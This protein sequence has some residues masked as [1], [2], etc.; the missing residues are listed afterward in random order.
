MPGTL[1]TARWGNKPPVGSRLNRAHPLAKGLSLCYLVNEPRLPVH[2]YAGRYNWHLNEHVDTSNPGKFRGNRGLLIEANSEG[3]K[4]DGISGNKPI[5]FEGVFSWSMGLLKLSHA[6]AE[7]VTILDDTP[8]TS[9]LI[10]IRMDTGS[11]D[12]QSF[13]RDT[14]GV[15]NNHTF[16]SAQTNVLNKWMCLTSNATDQSRID[17]FAN[18]VLQSKNATNQGSFTFNRMALGHHTSGVAVNECMIAYFYLYDR[19]FSMHE[20]LALLRN[21]YQ[22]FHIPF[23]PK[24]PDF[25]RAPIDLIVQASIFRFISEIPSLN[26]FKAL[27]PQQTFGANFFNYL[28]EAFKSRYNYD[29]E[30]KRY[31]ITGSS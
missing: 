28:N 30:N 22:M 6:T 5:I 31:I 7:T 19:V 21:P 2:D 15:N 25:G 1:D 29:L 4:R 13:H 11:T 27:R 23:I 9:A 8:N 3:V 16:S 17:C 10:L 24:V 12:L 20:H 18:G 26:L 14:S